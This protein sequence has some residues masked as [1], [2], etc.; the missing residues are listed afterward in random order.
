MTY[1]VEQTVTK[2]MQI[3]KAIDQLS[4][5]PEK[6]GNRLSTELICSELR[7]KGIEAVYTDIRFR[8]V[9]LK[10]SNWIDYD[11]F[12]TDHGKQKLTEWIQS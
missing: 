6:W 8:L 5:Q 4:D 2:D 9:V 7:E 3:L 11:Y 1:N 12:L 10:E